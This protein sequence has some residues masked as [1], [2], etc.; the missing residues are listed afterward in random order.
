MQ[1]SVFIESTEI[2]LCF[3]DLSWNDVEMMW[4][5]CQILPSKQNYHKPSFVI[6]II[7]SVVCRTGEKSHKAVRLHFIPI[8]KFTSHFFPFK[9]R[10][11]TTCLSLIHPT[12]SACFDIIVLLRFSLFCL[13]IIYFFNTYSFVSQIMIHALLHCHSTLSWSTICKFCSIYGCN[14]KKIHQ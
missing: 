13:L 9:Y 10:S 7:H 4:I 5:P 2:S 3:N 12:S 11:P 14:N 6:L 8:F 1:G